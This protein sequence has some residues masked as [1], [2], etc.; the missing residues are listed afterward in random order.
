MPKRKRTW[1][2]VDR[3]GKWTMEP[4]LIGVVMRDDVAPLL[5]GI[6]DKHTGD[7]PKAHV[8]VFAFSG[9]IGEHAHDLSHPFSSF[10]NAIAAVRKAH[11]S[12]HWHTSM[13]PTLR[14][15]RG[16]MSYLLNVERNG[17]EIW[18]VYA[19]VTQTK[20]TGTRKLLDSHA[21]AKLGV[22]TTLEEAMRHCET[23][24]LWDVDK[25]CTCE[26]EKML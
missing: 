17:A 19:V 15:K 25:L 7:A 26:A 13:F 3:H 8:Y 16:T 22:F 9:D 24:K 4:M 2:R 6:A 23:V 1:Q 12:V 20:Y 18:I 14:R 10:P 21:H 11:P 5:I